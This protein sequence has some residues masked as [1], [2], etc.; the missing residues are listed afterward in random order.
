MLSASNESVY[1]YLTPGQH[2]DII[3]LILYMR[4]LILNQII[5]QGHTELEFNDGVGK[6]TQNCWN[7]KPIILSIAI[8]RLDI[9]NYT[10]YTNTNGLTSVESFVQCSVAK[11]NG[12]VGACLQCACWSRFTLNQGKNKYWNSVVF[13]ETPLHSAN[14]CSQRTRK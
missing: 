9:L 7:S 1:I 2:V 12:N 11:T 10:N 3:I 6:Q 4:K 8:Y 5:I 14:V 13:Q